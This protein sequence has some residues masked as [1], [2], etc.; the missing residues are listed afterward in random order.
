MTSG[1]VKVGIV[2]L[3]RWARVL[4]RA[5]EKSDKLRI[6]AGIFAQFY[7]VQ[8]GTAEIRQLRQAG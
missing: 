5:V 4:A 6:V 8:G 7:A 1:P 3:G 2:G